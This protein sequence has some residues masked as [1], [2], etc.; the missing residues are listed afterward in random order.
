MS[1]S[2]LV[3]A[4][5]GACT[6]GLLS[7]AVAHA[8]RNPGVST[9][10]GEFAVLVINGG[11]FGS[12]EITA[13]DEGWAYVDPDRKRRHAT[14]IAYDVHVAESDTPANHFSHDLDFKVRLDPY[15]E[16]LLSIQPDDGLPVEWETG[17]RPWEKFGDGASPIFPKWAWPSHGDRVW[18]EGNWIYDCGHPQDDTGLYKTEI[19]PARALASMRERAAALPGTGLT[20]VPVTLTD[21]Y[22]SGKG[23]F[24]PNQ[25]NCG[26]GIVIGP[27]GNS[28]GED[29]GPEDQSYRT[30]PINDSDFTFDVCLPP[31]PSANAVLSQQV[32]FGPGNTVFIDP[33]IKVETPIGP[34]AGDPGYD[35]GAMLRVTVPLN[36]TATPPSAVYARRIYA[37]WLVPPDPVLPHRQ[38]T[39]NLTNLKEDH[40][41]DPGTGELSFWWM[42]VDL[43]ESAWLRLSDFADGNMNDYDDE[44]GLGNGEMTFTNATRDFYMRHGQNFALNS[45]GFE[46]DCFDN[47]FD[48]FW[49]THRRLE[50][51]MYVACYANF[52]D[53][54][55]GDAIERARA[56]FSVDDLGTR[57]ISDNDEYDL[58]VTIDEVAPNGEDTSH[59]SI[60]TECTPEGEVALV[61]QPLTCATQVNNG[62]TGLPRQVEIRNQF[63][64]VAAA[65]VNSA[66][67][68]IPGPLGTPATL[69][70]VGAG[71]L[72]RP[73][74]VLVALKTPVNMTTIATPTSPGLLTERAEV[75][76]AST[77]PDL[78]DNVKTTTIE[79][80]RPVTLDVLPDSASNVI[81]MNRRTSPSPSWARLTSTRPRSIRSASVSATPA[82]LVSAR[83]TNSMGAAISRTSTGTTGSIWC[84]TSSSPTPESTLATPA[85]A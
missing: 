6:I 40:D 49:F 13:P 41:L 82:R 43:A 61:G 8:Q 36:G 46:Q 74:T 31:R 21:L 27:H 66:T 15:Q 79:V 26:P 22:I 25:L 63:S 30:T 62:G 64:G 33:K 4:V 52:T 20:P 59:L 18:V 58:H 7:P 53:T 67:W 35:Q 50:L 17:I 76:T 16:D 24:A 47:M 71:A 81:N 42:D 75:T 39:L 29:P 80:F 38:V 65:T 3:V 45:Q 34:C 69:C 85:H 11:I 70:S 9:V 54:G 72:C 12:L 73:V 32:A 14:G 1:K 44:F 77:D 10:C 57:V 2:A 84:S 19:H 28:C 83:A 56:T 68:S 60:Q 78:T 37:G 5:I 55:A 23:G 51:V 48:G